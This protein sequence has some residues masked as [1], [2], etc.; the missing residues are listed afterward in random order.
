MIFLKKHQKV[1]SIL[2]AVIILG[3]FITA[4]VFR[5]K[6]SAAVNGSLYGQSQLIPEE[7]GEFI[8]SG[9]APEGMLL[10]AKTAT[11]ELF[12][13][14]KTA[15]FAV[16]DI[17]SDTV[18]YSNPP[19]SDEDTVAV[20]EIK[21]RLK[22][23]VVIE[24]YDNKHQSKTMDSYFYSTK[25]ENFNIVPIS[26][27]FRTEYTI[28]KKEFRR[29]MLPQVIEKERF[30]SLILNTV[31]DEDLLS[32]IEKRYKL[33]VISQLDEFKQEE[34]ITEYPLLDVNKEFYILNLYTPDYEYG[35]LYE[36]IFSQSK[37]TIEDWAADN[38]ANGIIAEQVELELLS[39]PLEVYLDDDGLVVNIPYSQ[40]E[41]PD[42][43][44]IKTIHILEYFGAGSSEEEGY[45]VLPDGSGSLVNFNNG[46]LDAPPYEVLVYGED[47]SI[48]KVNGT[49]KFPKA[50]IPVFAERKG[51][52]G[53]LAIIQEGEAHASIRAEVAGF[54][55]LYN[56][57]YTS[58]TVLP[59]D[60]MSI[61]SNQSVI[62]TNKY[63]QELYQGN[64]RISYQFTG[65]NESE[66]SDFALNYRDYLIDKQILNDTS[67]LNIPF[68]AELVG[69][70]EV[71]K[72]ILGVPY[73][74]YEILTSFS[75]SEKIIEELNIQGVSTPTIKFSSW[76]SGSS[77][78][79]M[80]RSSNFASGIKGKKGFASLSEKLQSSERDL[81]LNT[82]VLNIYRGLL[83]F[84][85]VLYG[86][87]YTYNEVVGI[88]PF[89]IATNIPAL[90]EKKHYLLSPR[91]VNSY[92]DSLLSRLLELGG[93]N[94]WLEDLG[95]IVYSDFSKNSN[96]DRQESVRLIQAALE[97][98]SDKYMGF[99]AP[100]LYAF[101]FASQ[102]CNIPLTSSGHR[103]EDENIPF[104]S[105]VLSG[106]MEYTGPVINLSGKAR[107][108]ML[109]AVETGSGL[110]FK[111]IYADN[112]L[113]RSLDGPEPQKLYS[114][115]YH[116]WV[117]QAGEFYQ[118][119]MVNMADMIGKPIIDHEK[120]AD[121]VYQTHW[122]TGSVIVNYNDKIVEVDG[123]TIEAKDYLVV[124]G[125]K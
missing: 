15:E 119:M 35:D 122:E 18:W 68:I 54:N 24:Y 86:A 83:D 89:N 118:D 4:Y 120:L 38:E 114:L 90:E 22:S 111:W 51:N 70:V 7:Q 29:D 93:E 75:D 6:L 112:T 84:N 125:E 40:V 31:V 1:I 95:S 92:I 81:Y 10:S 78:L 109:K 88:R 97:E 8:T 80:S 25:E 82:T 96:I 67:T 99:D 60:F 28:G 42:S 101:P 57:I 55:S 26:S 44:F 37:Y 124:K 12:V 87:R 58:Y 63:Q 17:P 41:V 108:D 59:V 69:R 14:I 3:T 121:N 115:N 71:E 16:H 110:Y 66:Y 20:G 104:L 49:T 21:N 48:K 123:K 85:N 94:V 106:C 2:S 65:S 30:E 52:A 39:V 61:V 79:T 45:M 50:A 73:T 33:I 100:N 53:F 34:Y 46:K 27:G 107:D 74:S 98:H 64:A 9:T 43:I 116:E 91:Y 76:F 102:A 23:Q 32:M 103:L 13:N 117:V 19:K 77:Q 56:H 62:V 47:T 105:I 36:A 113:I 5:T 72:N 11:T